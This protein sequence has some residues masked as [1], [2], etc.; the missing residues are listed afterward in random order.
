MKLKLGGARFV[1][2]TIGMTTKKIFSPKMDDEWSKLDIH[3]FLYIQREEKM[4]RE[5]KSSVVKPQ[6]VF[7]GVRI[8]K[9]G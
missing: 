8:L 9:R 3:D 5:Q 4:N 2:P 6:H 7:S 1:D